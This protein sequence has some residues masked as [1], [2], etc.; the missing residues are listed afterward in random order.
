[1]KKLVFVSSVVLGF[2]GV[3]ETVWGTFHFNGSSDR[4]SGRTTHQFQCVCSEENSGEGYL[5]KK[6]QDEAEKILASTKESKDG[7]VSQDICQNVA[8]SAK[9]EREVKKL[10]EERSLEKD[11]V[12]LL[13]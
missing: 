9:G 7:D 4:I 8:N 12:D 3:N 13:E 10:Q 11:E 5:V 6:V 2:G 1:M